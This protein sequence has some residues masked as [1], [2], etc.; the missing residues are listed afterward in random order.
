[1]DNNERLNEVSNR[2]LTLEISSSHFEKEL[3]EMKN[4]SRMLKEGLDKINS[5]IINI[6]N[7]IIGG[8]VMIIIQQY[9]ILDAIKAFFSFTK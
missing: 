3:K 9:G 6:K 4:E 5:T 1:M 8:V 2:V 7:W